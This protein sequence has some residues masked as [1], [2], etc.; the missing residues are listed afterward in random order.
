MLSAQDG[1]L[2]AQALP[3]GCSRHRALGTIR[4]AKS[5]VPR[6]PTNPLS[7]FVPKGIY[8]SRQR[9]LKR[10]KKAKNTTRAH[11]LTGPPHSTGPPAV[12][13]G[14]PRPDLRR[15]R[16][17]ISTS[18]HAPGAPLPATA[19]THTAGCALR[20]PPDAPTATTATHAVGRL[21]PPP[22]ATTM[23]LRCSLAGS[24][25]REC[26]LRERGRESK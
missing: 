17:H 26:V 6:A 7:T 23:A 12:N 25:E 11:P 14:P 21:R 1:F 9:L 5:S 19:A 22:H 15:H 18:I 4:P 3:R 8:S 16:H 2:S 10:V 20:P 13:G 24:G